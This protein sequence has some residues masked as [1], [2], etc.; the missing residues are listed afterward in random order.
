MAGLPASGTTITGRSGAEEQ[1]S[2][3]VHWLAYTVVEATYIV[4]TLEVDG[5]GAPTDDLYWRH[6]LGDFRL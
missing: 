2:R 3:D 4:T 6:T 5:F 1:L